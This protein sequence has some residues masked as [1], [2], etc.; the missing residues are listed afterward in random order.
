MW[1]YTIGGYQ[2]I[3][4]WLSY[5]ERQVLGRDITKDEAREFTHMVRRVAALLLLEPQLDQNYAA[6][7]I[8]SYSYE[9]AS[10]APG[11]K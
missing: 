4:K 9:A 5:R 7:K 1:E 3:K 8:N 2:V 10:A 11:A 6:T